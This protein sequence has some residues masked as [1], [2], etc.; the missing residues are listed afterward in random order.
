MGLHVVDADERH[1]PG[2]GERLGGRDADEQRADQAGPDGDGDSADLVV[3]D[4]GLDD[5]LSDH[6]VEQLEVGPPGDL[7]NDAAV[8]GVQ[9]DLAGHDAGQ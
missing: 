2:V 5:R 9:I 7:G 1:V 3:G 4:A 8:H 6:R